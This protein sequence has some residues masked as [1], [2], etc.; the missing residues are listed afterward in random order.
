[1][2]QEILKATIEVKKCMNG[3]QLSLDGMFQKAPKPKGFE[4][5]NVLR[6]VAKF[7]V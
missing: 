6:A 1:M 5:E 2:P 4:R 3:G 7:V